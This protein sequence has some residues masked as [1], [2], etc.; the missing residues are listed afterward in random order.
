MHSVISF[1]T[2][3]DGFISWFML[4]FHFRYGSEQGRL[5]PDY[6]HTNTVWLS[7]PSK[8]HCFTRCYNYPLFSPGESCVYEQ[9]R[10]YGKLSPTF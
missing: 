10:R 9:S 1:L 3:F 4:D 5:V 7:S 6:Y 2:Y 8:V